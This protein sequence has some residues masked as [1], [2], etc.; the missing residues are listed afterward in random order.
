[1]ASVMEASFQSR[2]EV[3]VDRCPVRRLSLFAARS[4]PVPAGSQQSQGLGD[5]LI[6]VSR[7]FG[8]GELCCGQ[9]AQG[10]LDG[11]A[12]QVADSSDVAA[13]GAG[14]VQ[15]AVFAQDVDRYPGDQGEPASSDRRGPA[16]VCGG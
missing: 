2:A 13:G 10:S 4:E 5:I 11:E 12:E 1:M 6:T 15:D 9:V 16:R 3:L 8:V 14:F 7:P